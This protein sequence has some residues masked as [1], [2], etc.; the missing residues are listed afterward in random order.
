VADASDDTI[1]FSLDDDG[2]GTITLNRPEKY[3]AF[4]I[5]MIRL[6]NRILLEVEDDDRVRVIVLTGSGKAFC[7]GGDASAMRKRSE[8]DAVER[9]NFLWRHVQRIAL[10]MERFDKPVIA[11]I[12]GP[13]RGAGLDMALMCD[14]RFMARSATLA[15]SY[16]AMGLIA[17]DGGTWYLPRLIGIDRALE[18]FWTGRSVG[19]DEAE[20]IGMVTRVIDDADLLPATYEFARTIARQPSEAVRMYKRSVY[21]GFTMSLAAHLDMAS[22]HTAVIRDTPEHRERVNAFLARKAARDT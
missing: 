6:W 1:L 22:S 20:R 14:M 11:A 3:N 12:N 2:I 19:A 13:A 9:K 18:L 10:T 16:I 21:Q 7:A 4:T 17:G 15:E 8:N 5:D